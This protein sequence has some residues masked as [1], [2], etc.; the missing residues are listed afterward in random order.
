MTKIYVIVSQDHDG[1][2][3]KKSCALSCTTPQEAVEYYAK[4]GLFTPV[5][6]LHC[7]EAWA[8][9]RS[10]TE[11]YEMADGMGQVVVEINGK[12]TAMVPKDLTL[13]E[14]YNAPITPGPRKPVPQVCPEVWNTKPYNADEAMAAVRAMCGGK[15]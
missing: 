12:Y 9:T 15:Q 8:K 13:A 11:L 6:W 1:N 2:Y 10:A 3:K 7:E 14:I 4:Y 5:A